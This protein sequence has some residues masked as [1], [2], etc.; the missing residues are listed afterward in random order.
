MTN[1]FRKDE[2]LFLLVWSSGYI[3][4]KIGVPVS[5]TF[6]LLFYRFMLVLI[7]VGLYLTLKSAW[8]WP[9]RPM[10]IIVFF[11]HFLWLV[12]IFK[13]F[14]F[15]ITAGAASLIA[16]LQPLLTALVS[17]YVLGEGNSPMKWAGIGLRF[18]GVAVFVWGD[19]GYAAVPLWVYLLPLLATVSLTFVTLYE[20]RTSFAAT[21]PMGIMSALFWHSA[22]TLVCLFPFAFWLE[23]FAAYWGADFVFAVVWLA[24]VVSVLAYG[25]MFYLIRTRAATRVSA[26]QYFVPPT[27]MAIAFIV[28][29]EALTWAGSVGL[30]ITAFGFY[31]MARAEGALRP[32]R[33]V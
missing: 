2:I 12:A 29:G 31:V 3:G 32:A 4:A 23:D 11:A 17:P 20:R 13:A 6:T 14:E 19:T 8:R 33:R 24:V 25:L 18:L 5:G 7:V 9:S 15:G 27:T 16:A 21:P 1:L 30:V 28:F 26:L 10:L 22:L